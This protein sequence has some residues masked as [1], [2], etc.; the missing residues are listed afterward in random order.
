DGGSRSCSSRSACGA[1]RNG[2]SR[3][4]RTR[5]TTDGRSRRSGRHGRLD[6]R[7]DRHSGGRNG[8][9]SIGSLE[10]H[11]DGLLLEWHARRLL[12][13]S[14]WLVFVFAHAL[15]FC[16]LRKPSKTTCPP[17]VKPPT[18]VFLKFA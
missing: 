7:S 11:A 17:S 13:R 1:K 18:P 15:G 3:G 16:I 5:G 8:W 14:R 9:R 2:R 4:G 6:R 12:G 10:R